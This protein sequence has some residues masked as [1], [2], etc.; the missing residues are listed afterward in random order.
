MPC[1]ASSIACQQQHCMMPCMLVAAHRG[2]IAGGKHPTRGSVLIE[3]FTAEVA[4]C[5][6]VARHTLALQ[7]CTAHTVATTFLHVNHASD[8]SALQ[9]LIGPLEA[10]K[11][12][13]C[14][15]WRMELHEVH[16]FRASMQ[17]SSGL[18]TR[19]TMCS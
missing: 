9:H 2:L 4:C 15:Y 17:C 6:V 18:Y 14:M 19:A 16:A 10:L 11:A 8:L 13:K 7:L 3:P 5:A 12:L 1:T